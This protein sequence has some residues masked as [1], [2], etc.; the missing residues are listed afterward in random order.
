MRVRGKVARG[1]GAI[2]PQLANTR[3]IA[4]AAPAASVAIAP[5]GAPVAIPEAP[6]RLALQPTD[7]DRIAN[8][9]VRLARLERTVT[10]A[11]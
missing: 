5:P 9:E 6:A 10:Q 2:V 1:P 7:A 4:P 3:A 8:L 11:G